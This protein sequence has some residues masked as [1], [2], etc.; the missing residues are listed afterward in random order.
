MFNGYPI[1]NGKS[2][3][4]KCFLIGIIYFDEFHLFLCISNFNKCVMFLEMILHYICVFRRKKVLVL[5]N[6]GIMSVVI[7]KQHWRGSINFVNIFQT[8]AYRSTR[9]KYSEKHPKY[10]LNINP[11]IKSV[12]YTYKLY[13]YD[14][15]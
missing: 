6:R 7:H 5:T 8:K 2:C 1:F 11:R 13:A 10:F 15:K 14:S 4:N 12:K 9:Y 3:K